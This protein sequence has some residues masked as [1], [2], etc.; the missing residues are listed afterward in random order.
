[1]P[2]DSTD[3]QSEPPRDRVR[4]SAAVIVA[5]VCWVG[6][7]AGCA[8]T[9]MEL[10]RYPRTSDAFVRANTV[11]VAAHVSGNIVELNV[12]DNQRVTAGEV[13]FVVDPRPYEAE[14]ERLEAKLVVTDLEI[15]AFR[16][17]VLAASASLEEM[18][19]ESAY[20]VSY[21]A[22]LEPLLAQKFV[23]PNEVEKARSDAQASLGR[24][25]A[26]EA[27]LKRA[28]RLVG[29]DLDG[30]AR[31]QEVAASL[32][33][34]RLNIEYCFVRA[35]VSGYV[36]NLNIARGEYA[37]QGV[38]LFTV[39]DDSRWYVLAN[40]RETLLGRIEP[41]MTAEVWLLACPGQPLK[42]VVEGIGKAIFQPVGASVNAL[43]DVP[44]ALDWVRLAQRFPVRIILEEAPGCTLHSGATATV[45]INP[46]ERVGHSEDGIL[47]VPLSAN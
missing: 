30:N 34:A 46:G 7:V 41:G 27:Q 16:Q 39:V 47:M 18:L 26:A 22:R 3:T 38:Q 36:S 29:D 23:T 40:Y 32:A 19:A 45:R 10:V 1:M 5:V 28:Q 8:L 14:V 12:R 24:V 35:Q 20:A 13:L 43:P 25:E 33:D 44:P 42:G 4:R 9:L 17:S 2:S 31:R 21:L 37:N 11:G 6:A 15:E